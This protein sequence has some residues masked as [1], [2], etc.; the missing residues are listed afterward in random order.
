MIVYANIPLPDSILISIQEDLLATRQIWWDPR[1]TLGSLGMWHSELSSSVFPGVWI[2]SIVNKTEKKNKM[3][4]IQAVISKKLGLAY[5][6]IS[7]SYGIGKK[8]HVFFLKPIVPYFSILEIPTSL[9][10]GYILLKLTNT[11]FFL[12][13][14]NIINSD[15]FIIVVV[16]K[17][18]GSATNITAF[19]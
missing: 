6:S 17:N 15:Y 1:G 10:I 9:A 8:K 14:S 19:L 13:R 2:L 7:V 4:L 5:A 18:E 3:S 16:I 11:I 12:L